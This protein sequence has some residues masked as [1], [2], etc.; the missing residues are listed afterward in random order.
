MVI[1][2]IKKVI[3]KKNLDKNCIENDINSYYLKKSFQLML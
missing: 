2:V 1:K 3:I